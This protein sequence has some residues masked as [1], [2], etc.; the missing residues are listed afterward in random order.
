MDGTIKPLDPKEKGLY[1]AQ[2][3]HKPPLETSLAEAR[4]IVYAVV[5]K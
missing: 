1:A 3:H 2:A 5:L 4:A